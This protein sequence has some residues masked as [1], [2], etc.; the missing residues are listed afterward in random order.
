MNP[1]T[2]RILYS[3]GFVFAAILIG[4]WI[5]NLKS[6][7]PLP[8]QGSTEPSFV[9]DTQSSLGETIELDGFLRDSD[10][11]EKGNLMLVAKYK[12][13]YLNTVRDYSSMVGSDVVVTIEGTEENFR[14]IDIKKQ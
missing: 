5:A 3:G 10:D 9:D 2:K 13:L 4:V 1:Q 8:T 14:L 6:P 11:I 12:T 7:K